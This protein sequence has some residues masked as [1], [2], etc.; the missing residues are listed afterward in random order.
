MF[1]V[2]QADVR[3][4]K[5]MTL[6]TD[7]TATQQ[8]SLPEELILMLLNEETGYFRQIAGWDLNCAVVGAVLAELS[9]QSRVDTDM[10]SLFL[11]DDAETSDPVLDPF[12]KAIASEATQH[13]AQ[14]WIERFASHADAVIDSVLGRLVDLEILDH[15]EGDYWTL[16]SKMWRS[17]MLIDSEDGTAVQFVKARIANVIFNN[18]IPDPRD[19][20][21]V[22][23]INTCDVMRFTFQLDEDAEERV[24]QICRMD[25]IARAI[26]EAVTHNMV[27]PALR[28]PSL[29]KPIPVAPLREL[30][31]N[32]HIRN[33]NL[34][35]FFADLAEKHGPVFQI[36][37]PF[38]KQ[39]ITVL[40]GAETNYWAHRHGRNY[41]RARDYL[42][43][44]E[45]VYGAS[46][47]LPALD[48]ADHFRFR[49]SMNSAYS[50]SR[51]ESHLG[52][53]FHHA[54][55][56]MSDW[57]VGDAMP[58]V[59]MCR[60]MINA[61]NSP[62][63]ISVDSQDLIDDLVKYK[64]RALTTHVLKVMPKFMLNTPGMRRRK[65]SINELLNRVQSGHTPAQRAGCPR[66]LADD[67][68]S[69]HASDPQFM[70]EA[71]LRFVLSA[72]LIA[73]VYLGDA[74][75]FC[76]YAMA[77]QP[78]LYK[79]IRS[80]ADVLFDDGDPD[81]DALNPE[82]IDVT[83]RF[84]LETLR[85]YSIVPMSLRTVMN[86]CS[87]EGYELPEG[88]PVHIAQA[89][90]H[91][92][93]DIFPDP[94]KFDIDRYLPPRNE[95]H[96]S[97]YA[98]FGLG[99]HTCLGSRQM[100]LHLA[101]NLLLIAHYFTLE[102]PPNYKLKIDPFPSLSVSKKLKFLVTEQRREVKV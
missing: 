65:K 86:T 61:Q 43:D 25:L 32:R 62:V 58:A 100:E 35:A 26:S 59:Q 1:Q 19:I 99:T 18:E 21:I 27:G 68:L 6:A 16:S 87:V 53:V 64:T 31:F 66:D 67:V 60:T 97:G 13:D 3:R 63:M 30:V 89:A 42:E 96:S 17:D 81:R 38:Q 80:E 22:S 88:T 50:R 84:I 83:R 40:A 54:R 71:N 91:Y 94:W 48:G 93:E 47:I 36:R 98:P 46:G 102:V 69:L 24:E 55:E 75:G 78:Q 49:K 45:K 72:P 57:A 33:G 39:P 51:L 5:L 34:N 41:L 52:L 90:A 101:I 11:I 2:Y 12:L 76:L 14:Y 44:F 23:L 70:P 74:L 28:R 7:G 92:M 56:Y 85:L 10:D 77:S 9:L 79:R 37:P 73:S 82:A 4:A 15:H 95:H 20:I 29:A 8:L